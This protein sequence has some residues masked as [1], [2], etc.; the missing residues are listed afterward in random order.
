M[1][2]IVFSLKCRM[3]VDVFVGTATMLFYTGWANF[4]STH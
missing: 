2:M 4:G 1:Q 3:D